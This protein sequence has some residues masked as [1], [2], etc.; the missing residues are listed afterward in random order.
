MF[1][2]FLLAVVCEQFLFRSNA[3]GSGKTLGLGGL[4]QRPGY[5]AETG[6]PDMGQEASGQQVPGLIFAIHLVSLA[7]FRRCVFSNQLTSIRQTG[8]FKQ[9][10]TT[11]RCLQ[12]SVRS[13]A[14]PRSPLFRSPAPRLSTSVVKRELL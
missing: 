10:C 12:G 1:D 4:G 7:C 14:A 3:D 5:R 8:E 6:A 9:S 11:D 13:S 2:V